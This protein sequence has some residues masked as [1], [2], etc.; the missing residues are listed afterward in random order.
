M[1]CRADADC[2]HVELSRIGLG[3]GNEFRDGFGWNGWT[4]LHHVERARNARDGNN[5][6]DKIE[7]ELVVERCIDGVGNGD[8]KESV[9]VWRRAHDSLGG[10]IGSCA[11]PVLDDEWLSQSL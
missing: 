5:V 2:G 11:R 7:T 8:F 9:A 6:T 10:D 4:D 3:V 1:C